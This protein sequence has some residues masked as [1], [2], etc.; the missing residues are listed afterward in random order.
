VGPLNNLVG[1]VVG[2]ASATR[3]INEPEVEITISSGVGYFTVIP[4]DA[5]V[6]VDNAGVQHPTNLSPLR[7]DLTNM[8]GITPTVSPAEPYYTTIRGTYGSAQYTPYVD[9]ESVI[10]TK[11]QNVRDGTTQKQPTAN[12]LARIY[13][14]A[15]DIAPREMSI[16]FN[17]SGLFAGSVDNAVGTSPFVLRREFQTPKVISWNTTE[18]IDNI[19]LRVVDYKGQLLPIESATE[20]NSAT[21]K[22]RITNTADFQ[23]TIQAT[24]Q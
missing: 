20:Y 19:D 21:K 24:E 22:M 10:M 1:V 6:V 23:F 11:N 18:N 5:Q 15:N 4:C 3:D 8:L 9:I 14:S 12:K 7:D 16:S 17:T 13:L 2:P